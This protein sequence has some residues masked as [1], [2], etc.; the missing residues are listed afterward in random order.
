MFTFG[1]FTS[2]IPYIAMVVFYAWFLF[3]G[4]SKNNSGKIKIAEK[5][6]TVQIHL[7]NSDEIVNAD[8]YCFYDAFT[9]VVASAV[10]EKSKEKQKWKDFNKASTLPKY[11]VVNTLFSRPPPQL[12]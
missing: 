4:L 1:I 2:H 10:F 8:N 12:V 5:S 9:H 11:F 3:A 6:A 7:N